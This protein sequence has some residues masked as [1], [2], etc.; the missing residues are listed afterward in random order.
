MFTTVEYILN[1]NGYI[2]LSDTY[3]HNEQITIINKNVIA[4]SSVINHY[5]IWRD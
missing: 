3:L 5:Y 2:E 1:L 4:Y